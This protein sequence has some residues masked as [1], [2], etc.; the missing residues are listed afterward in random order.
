MSLE[1]NINEKIKDVMRAKDEA[2]LRALRA[3]KSA[4][5]L[6]KTSGKNDGNLTEDIENKLLQKL[7]KQRKESIEVFEAQNRADLAD[8]EKEELAVIEQFLPE[9]MD[10]VA[11]KNYLEKLIAEVGA[12]SAADIGKVMGRA[13]KELAGKADGKTISL[14]AK[15]LLSG[16]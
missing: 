1:I 8:K 2:S 14:L 11:I 10:E 9:Q 16:S 4:I 15:S 13:S 5:L 12:A 6:E 7:A 3:I